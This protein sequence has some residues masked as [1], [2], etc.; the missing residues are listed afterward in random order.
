MRSSIFWF[1]KRGRIPLIVFGLIIF[2]SF[3]RTEDPILT[4]R[5]YKHR[6]FPSM[7]IHLYL[8]IHHVDCST[9]TRVAHTRAPLYIPLEHLDQYQQKQLYGWGSRNLVKGGQSRL[10]EHKVE[11][12]SEGLI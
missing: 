12:D 7:R 10:A 4:W 8:T 2:I 1:T 11:D 6:D 9:V 5:D 3:L